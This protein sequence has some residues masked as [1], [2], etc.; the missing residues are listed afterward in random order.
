MSLYEHQLLCSITTE[1]KGSITTVTPFRTQTDTTLTLPVSNSADTVTQIHSASQGCAAATR[2]PKSFHTQTLKLFN[3][4][5]V[6][7]PK[8]WEQI[9]RCLWST[10]PLWLH[11]LYQQDLCQGED[12]G[13][14]VLWIIE[15]RRDTIDFHRIQESLYPA[16]TYP[17]CLATPTNMSQVGSAFK[18]LQDTL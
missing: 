2:T 5:S 16:V 12:P 1:Q 10:E 15:P 7:L 17:A 4:I 11:A 3:A 6:S 18:E 13:A 9:P 8:S 14:L